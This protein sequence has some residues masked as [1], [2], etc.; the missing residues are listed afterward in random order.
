[1]MTSIVR[2]LALLSL[3]T[4]VTFGVV[5]AV[6]STSASPARA[7]GPHLYLAES[8]GPITCCGG[9]GTGDD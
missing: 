1:M 3:L 5:T 4:S 2:A 6:G 7:H 9:P 8:R